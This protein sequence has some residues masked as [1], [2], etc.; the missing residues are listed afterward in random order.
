MKIAETVLEEDFAA[1][2]MDEGI[3]VT[4][5]VVV[6]MVRFPISTTLKIALSYKPADCPSGE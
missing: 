4:T 6:D 2:K 5:V 3:G 1:L